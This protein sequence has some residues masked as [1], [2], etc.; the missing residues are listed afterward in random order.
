MTWTKLQDFHLVQLFLIKL[1]C[2]K[3]Q[4]SNIVIS[5]VHEHVQDEDADTA[6]Q[7]NQSAKYATYLHFRTRISLSSGFRFQLIKSY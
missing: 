2:L 3:K 5:T 1:I 6:N 4:Q 7:S